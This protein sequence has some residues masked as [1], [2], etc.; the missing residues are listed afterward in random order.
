MSLAANTLETWTMWSLK[1]R[2]LVF[3]RREAKVKVSATVYNQAH[4]TLCHR[5]LGDG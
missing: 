1:S 5:A 2:E 3:K 4:A